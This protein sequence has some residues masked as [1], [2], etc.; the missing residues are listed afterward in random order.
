MFP[1]LTKA[2][3]T[4]NIAVLVA[5]PGAGKTT[6]APLA[7]LA[8]PWAERGKLLVLEPRRL[9]TRAA[10]AR[11]AANLGEPVGQTIGYRIRLESRVS[12]ATRIEVVTEGVFTR[13]ILDDPGLEGI[14]AVLFDEFHER[15]LDADLGLAFALNSQALL[16]DDLRIL[17]MSAT[18]DGARIAAALGNAP[19]IESQ[20]RAFD[21]ITRYLGRDVRAPMEA[22]MAGAIQRALASEVGGILAFLPGQGEILRTI[23]RLEEGGLDPSVDIFP[24]F[25]A[26]DVVDQDRAT[27]P[28]APGRRKVVLATSIAETSLTLQGV[29]IVL[30]SGWSRTAHWHAGSGLTRLATRRLS[31]AS[32]DQRRGRAG[33]TEPGVCWRLWDEAETRALRAFD[34]PAI[35]DADLSRLVLDAAKWGAPDLRGLV[36]LDP[37]LPKALAEAHAM[38][39]GLGA[40]DDAG[41]LTAH[42][43]AIGRLPLPPRLA[44][45]VLVG[46]R[47]GEVRRAALLAA[48]VA[49][50]GLGGRE[51]DIGRRADAL[52]RDSSP[53]GR[54]VLAMAE[55][56]AAQVEMAPKESAVTDGMLIAVAFPERIAKA[57]GD[58]GEYQLATGRGAVLDPAD[59][60]AG[61]PWLAVADLGSATERDRIVLAA[62]LDIDALRLA[63]PERFTTTDELLEA[64]G[65]GRRAR[66]LVRLGKLSVEESDLGSPDPALLSKALVDDV[67]RHGLAMLPWGP[68]SKRFKARVAFL[69]ANDANWPD[70]GDAVLIE[71]LDEWLAPLLIGGMG[72]QGLDDAV[73]QNALCQLLPQIL[74]AKI[75]AKAPT[76]W[77]APAGSAHLIDYDAEGGPRVEVRVQAVFGLKTHPTVG[78]GSPLVLALLSPAHRPIQLTKDLPG[79]WAGSWAQVRKEMRGRYPRH[80]W[81]DDP[82]H[83]TPTLRTKPRD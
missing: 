5:P 25:G 70:L 55:R 8:E 81:P 9:A 39:V 65:G 68:A 20:G 17:V 41:V 12:A 7:L 58:V 48:V 42:G 80:P 27:A 6:I 2:L 61:T 73:L 28:S 29:R 46:A 35:L 4:G 77:T 64:G 14:A 44:H 15:N 76:H 78:N 74:L 11:M 47:A 53:R 22:Q 51:T 24:L 52:T 66:R 69:R 54:A 62:A 18:L 50:R 3:R 33:R 38:L 75:G 79:F 10:A 19:V 60:L 31:R 56:W 40:L 43:H 57:R 26:L 37:P 34:R 72:L 67:R 23:R 59:P 1:A 13:M 30:D 71:R 16:R 83:S 82:A 49:E 21:V 63:F 45:M 32:A 36:F